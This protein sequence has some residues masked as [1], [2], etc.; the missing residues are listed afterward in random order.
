MG[1]P[2]RAADAGCRTH[3]RSAASG[4][5][6]DSRART[7]RCPGQYAGAAF[8]RPSR[9]FVSPYV[10]K[11][12]ESPH[13]VPHC[14]AAALAIWLAPAAPRNCLTISQIEFHPATWASDRRPPDVL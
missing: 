14:N 7:A 13:A 2:A 11:M 5:A 1:R 12:N 3:G 4:D 8:H 9:V 6:R 10:A